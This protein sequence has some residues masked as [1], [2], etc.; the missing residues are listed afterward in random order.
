MATK[1]KV[2]Q[3]NGQQHYDMPPTGG[4][5]M[6]QP[7]ETQTGDEA[8][9]FE[10]V[11]VEI[12][13]TSLGSETDEFGD[14][15]EA[16]EPNMAEGHRSVNSPVS[17]M[18]GSNEGGT[19]DE[20]AESSETADPESVYEEVEGW[21]ENQPMEAQD[22]DPVV[23]A[24]FADME[25]SDNGQEFFGALAALVLP[26]A[27]AV[28]PTLAGAA[29]KQGTKLVKG[30]IKAKP[31]LPP[32]IL[33]ALRQAGVNPAILKQLEFGEE[34]DSETDTEE[35]SGI[36]GVDAEALAQQIEALE[37]V[38]G[39]DDRVRVNN[40]TVIP[41][42]RICHLK[43][44]T[45]DGKSYLGTGFFVGPRT[46]LTAGHCVYIHGHGGWPRQIVVTPGR[47]DMAEPFQKFTATAFR[48][49][50]GWVTNKSR[51][52]DYGV[53]QL[54]KNANVSPSIGAFGFG[55]FQDQFLLNKRLNTA[56]YPG[57]KPSGT[58]WFNGRKA[59]GVT[60]RTITYDIDTA[61]G[62][63]GSP[64]WFKG[65]DGQRIVV[66]IHTNGASTG[67]SATRISKPVFDNIK[68]W[69]AEGG[70]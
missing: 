33:Q 61:G 19:M 56:G 13:G 28:L 58:M 65:T 69:R 37:V 49:V 66:G 39:K 63:S 64:V 32:A 30:A 8:G 15:T 54:P 41:W 62:Q 38:I 22:E 9:F 14:G 70:A 12:T 34:F 11:V 7:S 53:I 2:T 52:F 35:S 47:N 45:T 31:K 68:K 4:G 27:K 51:N 6:G 59:K 55:Q 44:L 23:E 57:D 36:D 1:Y 20:F 46:I 42:K 25:A 3:G 40:T 5:S 10:E 48:S 18:K 24:S 16:G 43:I 29:V 17:R 60:S 50:Q 67:N 26:L 21:Q